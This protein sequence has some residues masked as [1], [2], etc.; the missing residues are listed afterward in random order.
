[1]AVAVTA[2]LFLGTVLVIQTRPVP[3]PELEIESVERG[4]LRLS[5]GGVRL[6]TFWATYCAPCL[7]EMPTLI[8][9]QRELGDAG[10]TVTAI[11]V[12]EDSP[13]RAAAFRAQHALPF[14]VAHDQ[15]GA[16]ARAFGE[17]RATPTSFVVDRE[18]RVVARYNG[19]ADPTELRSRLRTLLGA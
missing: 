19:R 18:G 7:A 15:S 9:L 8:A 4:S 13:D 12:R 10:L 17:V 3:L 1:M 16:A 2:C 5:H 6:V 14:A 11:A